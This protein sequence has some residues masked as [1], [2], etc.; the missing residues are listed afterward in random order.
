[1]A[2]I[3]GTIACG[4]AG[5]AAPACAAAVSAGVSARMTLANGGH[6]VDA[7]KAGGR[8]YATAYISATVAG[9][10]GDNIKNLGSTS[11]L[12]KSSIAHGALG[13]V[14]TELN[15]GKFGHGFA[16]S[17]LSKY[18]GESINLKGI[19]EGETLNAKSIFQ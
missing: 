10:I 14:M 17:F 11:Q 16:S 8:P 13:G 2:P 9:H 1:M 4:A 5:P 18:I 7:A 3:V 6:L 19:V 15:G 12:I